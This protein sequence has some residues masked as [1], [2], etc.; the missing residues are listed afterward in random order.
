M[1]DAITTVAQLQAQLEKLGV[2][3]ERVQEAYELLDEY[4]RAKNSLD[5]A[6]NQQFHN[7]AWQLT[8]DIKAISAKNTEK[9]AVYLR[10]FAEHVAQHALEL[11]AQQT[12]VQDIVDRIPKMISDEESREWR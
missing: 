5:S 6:R 1:Y 12:N 10:Q 4:S 2:K 11:S 8:A 3:P 9:I 7:E